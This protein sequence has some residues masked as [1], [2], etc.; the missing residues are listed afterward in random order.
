MEN[1]EL[2]NVFGDVKDI[3]KSMSP[4]EFKEFITSTIPSVL[5]REF[6]NCAPKQRIR[7]YTDRIAVACPYCGDSTKDFNAKRG[8]FILTGKHQGMYKCHNCGEYKPINRVF[9]DFNVSLKLDA[10]NYLQDIIKNRENSPYHKYD[11]NYMM[12]AGSLEELSIGREEFKKTLG[13]VEAKENTVI[14]WLNN[15]LQFGYDNYLFD[16]MRNKLIILNLTREKNIIG[17]QERSMNPKRFET[18]KLSKIYDMMKKPRSLDVDWDYFDAV[19]MLF[20]ICL[21]N[22]NQPV[23]A[24]EGPMDSYLLKNSIALTGASKAIPLE[25][26]VRYMFDY[27]KAGIKESIKHIES[28]DSV[29]LW[30]R[31]IND[32][33]LPHREKWDWNDVIIYF[34]NNGIN[35]PNNINRYFSKDPMD[36]ID[37]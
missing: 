12:D 34:R 24:M 18:Y 25:I 29:F 32:Y 7:S 28:G 19:S 33:N 26:N 8:N 37:I 11:A 14:S 17:I 3:D 20:N 15:R 30:G 22:F 21:V 13:L 36:I 23:T 10:I 16:P 1:V 27:D 6:P 5:E 2:F 4:L 31:F 9:S 35:I